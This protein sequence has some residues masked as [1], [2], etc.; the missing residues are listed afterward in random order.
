MS[1]IQHLYEDKSLYLSEIPNFIRD[2]LDGRLEN[3]QEKL[4]GQNFTFTCTTGFLGPEVRFLGK[5]IAKGLLKQGGLNRPE[6][7]EKFSGKPQHKTFLDAYDMIS[8]VV[9]ACPEQMIFDIFG[10][11]K[12]AVSAEIID[13]R[14]PN[15]IKYK[16]SG[17]R[18]IERI[19][20]P[21]AGVHYMETYGQRLAFESFCSKAEK[22]SPLS[23]YKMGLVPSPKFME[24]TNADLIVRDSLEKEMLG[25][26]MRILDLVGMPFPSLGSPG[27]VGDEM[28]ELRCLLVEKEL[29]TVV[30]FDNMDRVLR[31]KVAD[32]LANENKKAA[33][34]KELGNRWEL[35]KTLEARRAH[36][37]GEALMPLEG[38]FH[39]LGAVALVRYIPS[40]SDIGDA[41]DT[42]N[43]VRE[44]KEAVQ[45]G[46]VSVPDSRVGMRVVSAVKR[47]PHPS[48]H[49]NME[50]IV[51]DWKGKRRKLTGYFTPINRL[52]ALFTLG[53]NPAQIT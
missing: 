35:F 43:R 13:V 18:F 4:D 34:K 30:G 6:L 50:G 20:I 41:S 2:V 32:R 9:A 31:L 51:F 17:I 42:I 39:K 28:S 21:D 16:E 12:V 1:H 52:L 36:F 26:W 8:S 45:Q 3:V 24:W 33:G 22:L 15:V 10:D 53:E 47:C 46:R 25:E 7:S 37:V 48:L 27:E 29:Q 19:K 38:F 40:Y 14:N 5:G 23:E 49:I 11:G 44:I